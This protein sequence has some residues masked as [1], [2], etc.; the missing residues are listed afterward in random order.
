MNNRLYKPV[1]KLN[2]LSLML[3]YKGRKI[4]L[5]PIQVNDKERSIIWRND[6]EVRDM[7][8]SYRFPVTEVMEDNWYR[9]ALT[10]EDHQRVLFSI[11]NVDDRKHIGFANLYNLDYIASVCY[12]SILIGDKEEQGKGKSREA[13]HLL[14][15]FAFEH[16]NIRKINLEVASFNKKAIRLYNSFS[17]TTEGVLK[18]QLY[19]NGDYHDK[20]SMCIFKDD[21]YKKYSD[22]KVV[23]SILEIPDYQKIR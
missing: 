14:F 4:R 11:E 23:N 5:R 17:F 18:Q 12:F 3:S 2:Q 22:I 7:S 1:S 15:R 19:I 8:L 16:L 10:G 13:M 21:Y 6:P 20:I 9:K